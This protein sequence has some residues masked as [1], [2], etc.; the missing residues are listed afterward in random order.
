MAQGNIFQADVTKTYNPATPDG[1]LLAE[2][3]R[4][5]GKGKTDAIGLLGGT[6]VDAY[7]G[8]QEGGLRADLENTTSKIVKSPQVVEDAVRRMEAAKADLLNT[9]NTVFADEDKGTRAQQQQLTVAEIRF[10]EE[11]ARI[12]QAV[13]GNVIGVDEGYT[14]MAARLR[15]SIAAAPGF[16]DRFRKIAAELTGDNNLDIYELRQEVAKNQANKNS[17]QTEALK[18]ANDVRTFLEKNTAL[19]PKEI[20]TTLSNPGVFNVVYPLAV[21]NRETAYLAE[22]VETQLKDAKNRSEIGFDGVAQLM[23]QR[24]ALRQLE[25]G[26]KHIAGANAKG[27]DA[28]SFRTADGNIDWGKFAANKT[29]IEAMRNAYISDVNSIYNGAIQEVLATPMAGVRREQKEAYVKSLQER[30]EKAI[31]DSKNDEVLLNTMT[32]FQ[33]N[34]SQ[35][36]DTFGKSLA[37]SQK[38]VEANGGQ[39]AWAA[40]HADRKGFAT[41]NPQLG[42]LFTDAEKQVN[43]LARMN[44]LQGM[45]ADAERV[46][47]PVSFSNNPTQNQ[48]AW[49]AALYGQARSRTDAVMVGGQTVRSDDTNVPAQ[50]ASGIIMGQSKTPS[51][52]ILGSINL[53][54]E[55]DKTAPGQ[56]K[57]ALENASEMFTRH[58]YTD[59]NNP[60]FIRRAN[61]LKEFVQAFSKRYPGITLS[62]T[63]DD[64]GRLTVKVDTAATS[65]ETKKGMREKAQ[66][67]GGASG[68]YEAVRLLE[69]GEIPELGSLKDIQT[70]LDSDYAK[71]GYRGQFVGKPVKQEQEFFTSQ[72]LKNMQV[73]LEPNLTGKVPYTIK[74]N[75]VKDPQGKVGV[76]AQSEQ[77]ASGN[78][79]V[80]GADYAEAQKLADEA[81]AS[82]EGVKTIA[83]QYTKEE[84]ESEIGQLELA[85]QSAKGNGTT[86]QILTRMLGDFKKARAI[87]GE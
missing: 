75:D 34:A 61:D 29:T 17:A 28:A 42:K 66:R 49:S 78:K 73:P 2:A 62:F 25:S 70:K 47:K 87:Q 1:R 21:K 9:R 40:F 50:I 83:G 45:F 36:L 65:E 11:V 20:E 58:L 39:Q 60:V 81:R 57:A 71:A 15:Q 55:L 33:T 46:G 67:E 53:A 16:G 64:N 59:Q 80:S 85:L 12:R 48:V 79:T 41:R 68:L 14:R 24:I 43:D 32:S 7:V 72:V 63:A 44:T 31:A 52:D 27:F 6:A 10:K 69:Y 54:K 56:G 13:E 22:Q 5:S 37:N 86:R 76:E 8:Y 19:G 77:P 38:L 74:V 26:S 4:L 23:D 84:L 3:E 30:K 51:A 35:A 18:R 82:D